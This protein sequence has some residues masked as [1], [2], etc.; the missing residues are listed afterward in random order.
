MSALRF[1]GSA[2]SAPIVVSLLLMMIVSGICSASGEFP[3]DE[4]ASGIFL[5]RGKHADLDDPDRGDSANLAYIE[6]QRCLA[7]IDS[8]GSYATG[9]AFL[10]TIR[11]RT[12]KPVCYVINTHVHFDHVLGNAAFESPETRFVGHAELAEAIAANREFFA[13]TFAA[14]LGGDRPKPIV[15]PSMLV[16]STLDLDLGQRSL[17]LT[18]QAL[19]HSATDLTV[20]DPQ[21][22]T[23]FTGDLLF[24]ERLPVLDGSL[25]GWLAWMDAAMNERYALVVPGHGPLDRAWPA[26]AQAQHDY[27][28]ALRDGVRAAIDRGDLIDD[29][30]TVVAAQMLPLWQLTARAHRLNVSRA[31]RELE[32][33]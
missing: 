24:R 4:V 1:A 26:G 23:L 3:L 8:G 28:V 20:L 22:Q 17:H 10:D 14:E 32:W 7:I 25:K 19:A 11:A 2:M 18:A 30:Q 15:A 12:S 33:D 27:L 16:E 5:H 21:T 6:G 9:K 29:A 31:Y 13:A